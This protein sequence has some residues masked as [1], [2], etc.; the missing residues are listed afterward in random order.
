[1]PGSKRERRKEQE[2]KIYRR[3]RYQCHHNSDRRYHHDGRCESSHQDRSRSRDR[4]KYTNEIEKMTQKLI[5]LEQKIEELEMN[6]KE[7]KEQLHFNSLEMRHRRMDCQYLLEKDSTSK[8]DDSY[9]KH[10]KDTHH[11]ITNIQER[12]EEIEGQLKQIKMLFQSK[13]NLKKKRK[14][15]WPKVRRRLTK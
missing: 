7:V 1:M 2:Q 3:N 5:K 15:R 12:M 11:K 13:E 6:R 9:E 14:E 8:Y 4:R 10:V